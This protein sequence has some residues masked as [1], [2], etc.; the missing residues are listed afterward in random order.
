VEDVAKDVVDAAVEI[1]RDALLGAR[2]GERR[3]QA[4]QGDQRQGSFAQ[5][6]SW[7]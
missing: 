2:T 7:V 5:L 4:G 1:D 6:R 3:D